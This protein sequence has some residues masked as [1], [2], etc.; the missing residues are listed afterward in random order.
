VAIHQHVPE[1]RGAVLKKARE[2]KGL[3]VAEL[4]SKLC[5]SVKQIEQLEN[6]EK[7]HFYSLGIKATAAKKVADEL[8]LAYE[9][10]FDFGADLIQESAGKAQEVSVETPPQEQTIKKEVK[11]KKGKQVIAE[12]KKE[13]EVVIAEHKTETQKKVEQIERFAEPPKQS[14]QKSRTP[15]LFAAGAVMAIVVLAL[16]LNDPAPIAKKDEPV[17]LPSETI[18]N[19]AEQKKDEAV[20]PVVATATVNNPPA[21]TAVSSPAVAS[22]D[23]CP[24][25]ETSPAKYR[26]GTPSKP[27]N[28]VY[29]QTRAKQTVCVKD[30]SGKLERRS[31][32]EGGSYSFYGKAP[33]V[34]MT[35][36]LAQTDIFFQGYK[37][38][39][40]NPSAKTIVLEEVSN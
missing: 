38:R 40:D 4:A 2:A 35:A 31:M 19:A 21:I 7:R 6:G 37:V 27:G 16:Q 18:A 17:K 15:M 32:D 39:V 12:P 9:D 1:V 13:E 34:L 28:M 8:G 20:S 14:I 10:V 22:A 3:T 25:E 26:S 24:T 29:V 36:G 23:G 33:F 30:A 11:V 5:F